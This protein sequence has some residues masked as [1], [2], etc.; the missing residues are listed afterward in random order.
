[1]KILK[2]IKLVVFFCAILN[3]LTLSSIY[4]QETSTTS[5]NS[6]LSTEEKVLTEEEIKIQKEE[7]LVLIEKQLVNMQEK[8]KA[9]DNKVL[10]LKTNKE[11][12]KYPAIRLNLETPI[13]GLT[14]VI[15]Q[16]LKITKDVATIDVANNYSIREIIKNKN[17]KLSEKTIL[18]IT[19]STRDVKLDKNIELK[20]LNLV[21]LKLIQYSL[22]IDN[23]NKFLDN[24]INQ[25]FSEYVDEEKISKVEDYK[26]RVSE[27]KKTLLKESDVL[28]S[29]YLC[30]NKEEQY[31]INLEVYEKYK[32]ELYNIEKKLNNVIISDSELEMVQKSLLELETKNIDYL[33]SIEELLKVAKE[34]IVEDTMIQ[35]AINDLKNR[36]SR[37]QLYVDNST[38]ISVIQADNSQSSENNTDATTNTS[39]N[40]NSQ[41]STQNNTTEEKKMYEIKS[42]N[43]VVNLNSNL[44]IM[45]S[46]V[47]KYI[48][49]EDANK[50]L[51][52][53]EKITL[54]EEISKLYK[55]SISKENKFYLDNINYM[56]SNITNKIT[57]INKDEDT[58]NNIL[59]EMKYVYLTLPITLDSYLENVN[60]NSNIDMQKLTNSLYN[61]LVILEEYNA[62]IL[63]IYNYMLEK[64]AK[65]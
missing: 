38:V 1:M 41:D 13:F 27:V 57:Q 18:N 53:E 65:T 19:I 43:L 45:Q 10:N 47:E 4:A 52:T 5:T 37:L 2:T 8:I 39:N 51:T 31:K 17:I 15:N 33:A 12:E 24:Q 22:Q 64:N 32:K 49:S 61:E 50:E 25:T 44:K 23:V 54:L 30:A 26:K 40:S 42:S 59:K 63:E 20:D 11:Y 60:Y 7:A 46:Y 28:T 21:V 3:I 34:N 29:I 16:K 9:I 56:I 62:S 55:D 58:N 35:N 6:N 48:N 36:K 14:S